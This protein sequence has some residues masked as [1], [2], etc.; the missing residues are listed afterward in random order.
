M[1]DIRRLPGPVA[2]RWDWQLRGLCRQLDS[3][4]F[5]TPE[6]ERGAIRTRREQHAKAVC[7]RCPVLQQCRE[8]ALRAREP[9]GVWGGMTE[10]ERKVTLRGVADLA[11]G[12]A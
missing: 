4:V 9:Y 6:R 1:A 12:V 11:L 10:H 3:S 2:E 7:A 8:H 5:F